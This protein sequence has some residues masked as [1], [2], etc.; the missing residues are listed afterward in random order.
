MAKSFISD[1]S[2]TAGSNTD[3]AGVGVA[4]SNLVSQGDNAFRSFA[5]MVAQFY[6]DLGGLGT[7][8]GTGDA[9][10][11]TAQEAWTAYGTGDGQINNGTILAFKAGAANTGAVTI[12]VNAIG[13]KAIQAQGDTAL[14]A[15]AL[16]ANAVYLLR[17]DTAYNAAAGAWV[18]LNGGSA[19]ASTTEQLTGTSSAKAS[20][21]DS[22]AALWE[23]G[24]DV[25]SS[26]TISLGEG[27]YFHVT[28]TTTIT[29]IDFATAKDGRHA[30]LIFDAAL[31][32]THNSTTLKLPGGANITTEAGDRAIVVQDSSDNVVVV[33]YIRARTQSTGIQLGSPTA[34]TSGTAINFTGIPAG[35]KRITVQFAGVSTNS[36]GALC[37]RLGDSGGVET[38][39]YLVN[40]ITTNSSA[41]ATQ[42][43]TDGFTVNGALGASTTASGVAIF[44]LE[45]AA[46]NTWV[47]MV[48]ISPDTGAGTKIMIGRKAL[49]A[50]L[51]RVQVTTAGGTDTFDAGEISVSYEAP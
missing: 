26:G 30:I 19:A 45:S 40:S 28:G 47:G 8:G 35:T 24:S 51:D 7:V 3:L 9:I 5:A 33:A 38:S 27:G 4:G 1:L 15:G 32:L 20:T 14:G 13:T 18:L 39:G 31:T 2:T 25:A 36:T 16:V 11:L 34:S 29:D 42:Q 50:E 48:F 6:E 22:V 49:S 10:T 21:P 37:V 44:S 46:S 17:Y 41:I 43:Q 12:N 23:K